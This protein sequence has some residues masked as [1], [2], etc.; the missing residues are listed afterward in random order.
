MGLIIDTL[1]FVGNSAVDVLPIAIFLFA[2]QMFVIGSRMPNFKQM[3]WVFSSRD[4]SRRCSHS[5]D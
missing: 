2:F 4:S 3:D 5:V 1:K